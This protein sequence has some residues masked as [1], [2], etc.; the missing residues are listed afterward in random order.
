MKKFIGLIILTV[1][2]LFANQSF[3]QD[4]TFNYVGDQTYLSYTG[5]TAD[6]ITNVNSDTLWSALFVTNNSVPLTQ[7]LQ[8]KI[9]K[10]SGTPR[11]NVVL[12][13]KKF[14]ND[15]YTTITSKLWHGGGGTDTTITLSNATANRYRFYR[16]YFDATTATQKSRI[17]YIEFKVYKE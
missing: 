2:I 8:V 17:S 7:D 15:S 6:T 3:A 14:T 11:V 16:V 4:K 1:S 10:V 9:T 13:A 5:T 12:Q